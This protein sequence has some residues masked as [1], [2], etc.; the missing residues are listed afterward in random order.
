MMDIE[1]R[2]I[3]LLCKC[4][5]NQDYIN[6]KRGVSDNNDAILHLI[7]GMGVTYIT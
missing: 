3:Q 7:L 2:A 6:L 5:D 1:R 4:E